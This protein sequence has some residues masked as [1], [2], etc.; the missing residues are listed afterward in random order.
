MRSRSEWVWIGF[1]GAILVLAALCF[2]MGR[3]PTVSNDLF[4]LIPV[5][6]EEAQVAEAERSFSAKSS[7]TILAIVVN[8]DFA[9]AKADAG[10]LA[11]RFRESGAFDEV[12]EGAEIGTGGDK[13]RRFL[14]AHAY[15]LMD[16]E[17]ERLI[18][19]GRSA[20]V[21]DRSLATLFG[22]FSFASS[23][24][25]DEDPFLLSDAAVRSLLASFG[26]LGGLAPR[27]GVLARQVDG[28]WYVL[29]RGTLTE[30]AVRLTNRSDIARVFAAGEA[31][32]T[33]SSSTVRFSGVALHSWESAMQTQREIAWITTVSLILVFLLFLVTLRD[34]RPILLILL[35]IAL[36]TVSALL[37]SWI[38]FG[39]LH[40]LTLV[41]GTTLI[42]T[43][44][45]YS[46]HFFLHALH[47]GGD[48]LAVRDRLVRPMLTSY[49][50]T[51]LCYGLLLFA[52]YP[53][54][55]EIALFAMAGLSSSVVTS[56]CLYP[57]L[58][59]RMRPGSH[60]MVRLPVPSAGKACRTA[61]RAVLV[62]GCLAC[63]WYAATRMRVDNNLGDMYRMSDRMREGEAAAAKVLPYASSTYV[64]VSGSDEDQVL[65]RE[66]GFAAEVRDRNLGTPV[67]VSLLV[68]S[69]GVQERRL[70]AGRRLLAEQLPAMVEAAGVDA[71]ASWAALE[72]EEAGPLGL[73]A[74]AEVPAL[75]ALWLGEAD[76]TWYSVVLVLACPDKG[77]LESLARERDGIWYFDKPRDIARQLD[78]LT[79][80]MLVL[81][82]VGCLL[83][84]VLM[85]GVYGFRRSLGYHLS[86]LA[87]LVVTSAVMLRIDGSLGF[88]SVVALVLAIGLGLDYAVFFLELDA[89]RSEATM[90]AVTLS[91]LTTALSFGTLAFSTFPPVRTFGLAVLVGLGTA[92]C[93]AL[94]MRLA[95]S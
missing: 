12:E 14:A 75:Q 94:A 49:G 13:V 69:R 28:L 18:A 87:I 51:V 10:A 30:A 48:P 54:L 24:H 50:S 2:L 77:A 27:E 61:V 89:D 92:W 19:S 16:G 62:A 84:M 58:T 57:V 66:A 33:A 72:A 23:D 22:P 46:V 79:V 70:A 40:A 53:L 67:G 39:T 37:V 4:S 64:L 34:L 43:C 85:A 9:T 45:D 95:R 42:G 81:V 21:R 26:S 82:G 90:L 63:G 65:D 41:F 68:P 25:L 1:H 80:G 8:P 47:D 5:S 78:K 86:P 74:L 93:F 17:T 11:A 76:G 56:L 29:V 44:V 52:P 31:V 6:P 32:E 3:R 88:F 71:A 35:D 55:R 36:S 20:E 83:I 59:V 15:A 91:F 73:D 60:G 38:A 7:R